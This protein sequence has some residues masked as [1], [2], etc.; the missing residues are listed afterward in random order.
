MEST[1]PWWAVSP[2]RKPVAKSLQSSPRGYMFSVRPRHSAAVI[3]IAE[4]PIPDELSAVAYAPSGGPWLDTMSKTVHRSSFSALRDSSGRRIYCRNQDPGGIGKDLVPVGE[5]ADQ[6][7][8]PECA[9][10]PD[11]SS[12]S[13]NKYLGC[14]KVTYIDCEGREISEALIDESQYQIA[15]ESP[16]AS[17]SSRHTSDH[18]SS[19]RAQTSHAL[20]QEITRVIRHAAAAQKYRVQHILFYDSNCDRFTLLSSSTAKQSTSFIFR[21]VVENLTFTSIR[22]SFDDKVA[23]EDVKLRESEAQQM[24]LVAQEVEAEEDEEGSSGAA[25]ED[26]EVLEESIYRD[27]CLEELAARQKC[28]R[29]EEAELLLNQAQW[30]RS[31]ENIAIRQRRDELIRQEIAQSKIM[32]DRQRTLIAEVRAGV[33]TPLHQTSASELTELPARSSKG[34]V[35]ASVGNNRRR[36]TV[37]SNRTPG[38]A[39]TAEGGR[40]QDLPQLVSEQEEEFFA[41]SSIRLTIKGVWE[42]SHSSGEVEE[43]IL[44]DVATCLCITPECVG[45]VS[46][47][48]SESDHQPTAANDCIHI[49]FE[50]DGLRTDGE[51]QDEIEAY[52]FPN[53]FSLM[54]SSKNLV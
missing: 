4:E 3:S 21:V 52:D 30:R 32:Q 1:A 43:A 54:Q 34:S 29:E 51:L 49:V 12:T 46:P 37:S 25:A 53:L 15:T 2:A 45:L 11:Q 40:T 20:F 24:A 44:T 5:G 14:W 26:E 41:V 39:S 16:S 28:A 7:L 27:L 6:I 9:L 10:Q 36:L 17:S 38:R 50:H 18:C 47:S 31:N 42:T 22:K 48:S 33:L 23:E 19:S 8:L 13:G 35:V